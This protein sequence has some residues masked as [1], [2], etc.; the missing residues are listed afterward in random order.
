MY[1]SARSG[2]GV[3]KLLPMARKINKECYVRVGTGLLNRTLTEAVTRHQ[4]P[5]VKRVRPTFFY[6]T[7]AETNPPTFVFFVNDHE[8]IQESYA[9]Y[10]E[11][12]MRKRFEI[13]HAPMRVR[14]RSSHTKN[15]DRK[16]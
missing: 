5:V 15:R 11:K 2:R 6:L 3:D 16:K 10:L 1:I 9:R 13:E 14:F 8:R 7:Q 12:F 4:P